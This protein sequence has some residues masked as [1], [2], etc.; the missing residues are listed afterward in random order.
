MKNTSKIFIT[1]VSLFFAGYLSCYSNGEPT[2]NDDFQDVT[3]RFQSSLEIAFS[4]TNTIN[5]LPVLRSLVFKLIELDVET[6][7][8]QIKI[9]TLLS[10]F[11][12]RVRTEII[13]DFEPLPVVSNVKPP[14][15]GGGP[16]FSGMDP[17]V[18]ADPEAR[19]QYQEAI[20]INQQ[21]NL[22]NKRQSELVST[23]RITSKV[24][25]KYIADTFSDS[26]NKLPQFVEC[27]EKA[28]LTE[29]EIGEINSHKNSN[30]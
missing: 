15:S 30:K 1:I 14:I 24:V 11:L 9:A 27:I 8:E 25:V 4:Q 12:G 28:K 19:V 29:N 2:L 26:D 21:N 16:V 23:D 3:N 6:T 20:R 22:I 13:P 17:L 18:I 5:E 10:D 7:E